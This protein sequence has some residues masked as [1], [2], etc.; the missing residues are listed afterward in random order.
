MQPENFAVLCLGNAAVPGRV[1]NPRGEPEERS[2]ACW[3]E[4]RE[5]PGDGGVEG[6]EAMSDGRNGKEGG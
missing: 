4:G 1:C 3:G 2:E 6:K 5:R